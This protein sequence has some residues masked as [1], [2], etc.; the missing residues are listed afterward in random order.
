MEHVKSRAEEMGMK[1]NRDK[2]K[3]MCI[4]TAAS[5]KAEAYVEGDGGNVDSVDDMKMLGFTLQRDGGI[6][7]HVDTVKKKL[8]TKSWVLR[9]LRK[10]G[11]T[12][13][14]LVRVYISM[15]RPAAEY[16]SPAWHPLLTAGQTNEIERQQVQ[17]LKNIYGYEL[18]AQKLREKANIPLL[19]TRRFEACKVFATKCA[20]SDRFKHW[21]PLR[22]QPVYARREGTSYR[23]YEE[24]TARTDRLRNSPLHYMRRVLNRAAS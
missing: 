24:Y 20:K 7:K 6:S 5:Y 4:S 10:C 2:T 1:V 19:S 18:S 11:F 3:I 17:A 12:P 22:H 9:T 16:A 23:Q 15:I 14:E 13:D 8:R 21:F